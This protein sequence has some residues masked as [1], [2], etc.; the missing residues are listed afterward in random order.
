MVPRLQTRRAQ[1]HTGSQRPFLVE[2]CCGP[3]CFC[4]HGP[5]ASKPL[6]TQPPLCT[7]LFSRQADQTPALESGTLFCLHTLTFH[8]FGALISEQG[9]LLSTVSCCHDRHTSG[10][11][12]APCSTRGSPTPCALSVF[13]ACGFMLRGCCGPLWTTEHW[14]PSSPQRPDRDPLLLCPALSLRLA[15]W[16]GRRVC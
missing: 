12:V 7:W 11:L 1:V 2:V 16:E 4:L 10:S 6:C 8:D 15:D 3:L 14:H 5:V 13:A 9:T